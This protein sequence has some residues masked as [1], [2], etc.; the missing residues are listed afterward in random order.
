MPK[1]FQPGEFIVPN[2]YEPSVFQIVDD[3]TRSVRPQFSAGTANDVGARYA[4]DKEV[5]RYKSKY[6]MDWGDYVLDRL[7]AFGLVYIQWYSWV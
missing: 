4:S 6:D 3:P 1:Q 2:G 7:L 5:R